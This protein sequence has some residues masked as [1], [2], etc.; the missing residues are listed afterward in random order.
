[1]DEQRKALLQEFLDL[2][3][4]PDTFQGDSLERQRYVQLNQ[5]LGGAAGIGR[6][7]AQQELAQTGVDLTAAGVGKA[8]MFNAFGRSV[9]GKVV[10]IRNNGAD[11]ADYTVQI[12]NPQAGES[13]QLNVPAYM[14]K[15]TDG[16][17]MIDSFGTA[18]TPGQMLR[19]PAQVTGQAT[20]TPT[21]TTTTQTPAGAGQTVSNVPTSQMPDV[22]RMSHEELLA[23]LDLQLQQSNP[24]FHPDLSQRTDEELK[25]LLDAELRQSNPDFQ[26]EGTGEL[27]PTTPGNAK[28]TSTLTPNNGTT[29]TATPDPAHVVPVD[30]VKN[31][32]PA[33]VT[34][35]G[36]D[37]QSA[38]DAF[39][40]YFLS[41][42]DVPQYGTGAWD[43][44]ER[45]GGFLAQLAPAYGYGATPATG[46]QGS[47]EDFFTKY[48]LNAPSGFH[49]RALAIQSAINRNSTVPTPGFVGPVQPMSAYDT[50]LA[51][52]YSKPDE[53][54]N[55][56]KSNSLMGMNPFWDSGF[57]RGLRQM[58]DNNAAL[59]PGRRFLDLA[60]QQGLI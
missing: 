4:N 35:L 54:F 58:Y 21:A 40:R 6:D 48:G 13:P 27:T 22:T 60:I 34:N 36:F 52:T 44:S 8:V 55:L 3:N 51:G 47:F 10:G 2:S 57:T 25:A 12:D 23:Y 37:A 43:A 32:K 5:L 20:P 1:M 53:Q 49:D 24:D 19:Q 26:P 16:T 17:P 46:G 31:P 7:Q 56:V 18:T 30:T 29:T 45:R 28:V 9:T 41:R 11:P 38:G 14:L 42:P 39:R 15:H 50:A 59:N 33:D